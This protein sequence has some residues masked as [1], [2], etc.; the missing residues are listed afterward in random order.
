MVSKK[1]SPQKHQGSG[2]VPIQKENWSHGDTKHASISCP[3]NAVNALWMSDHASY[4]E[5]FLRK[6]VREVVEQKIL[7]KAHLFQR[8]RVNEAGISGVKPLKLCF[9]NK[10]P[11]TIFTRSNIIAE[12]ETPLQIA[13]I[14]VG[15]ESVVSDGPLSSLKI[16][17]YVLDGDFGSCGSEDWNEDEFNSN[18]LRERDGKEPLLI[19]ERII[20]LKNGVGC[21]T[22]LAFSDNSRWQRSR[23]FRIGVRVLQPISN[24]EKIQEAYK[25]HYPPYLNDDIWRLKNIAK[26]RKFHN[27]LSLH[28][29][30]KVKDLLRLYITNEPSLYEMFGNISR[31]SWLAITEHAK[32]CVIDDYKLYSYHSE[33]LQIGLLFN[34]IYILVGVTFDWQNYYSPDTL[35]PKEKHLVEIVKQ[36]AYRNVNNLKLIDD[37]K[38]NCLNLAAC[39]KARQS[40]TPDQGLQH[41]NISTAQVTLP[42]YSQP[43]ISAS[44]AD[45]GIMH[46]HQVYADLQP[47]IGEMSQNRYDLDEFSAGMYTEGDSLH[48][49]GSY[50]PF[51]QGGYSSENERS[52]IQFINDCPPY[53]TLVPETSF[54]IGSSVGAEFN[55]YSTFI[56]SAADISG[57]GKPK[58]VWY[59]ILVALKWVISIKRETA[60]RKNVKQFHYNY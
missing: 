52:V 57:T 15:S 2:K 28:G 33:E 49:N 54:F 11:D 17:I 39:L 37:T 24:G 9:I 45:E 6:V 21:I 23:R 41:I 13:L 44:Y 56:D 40:D 29:I 26:E 53:T 10:L 8:K 31:K 14:D 16:E 47:D 32:T 38:L 34:S 7:G 22:K 20:T 19:G 59:K 58:A 50:F 46:D 3:R 36:R 12:D 27:Q 43:F 30:H 5:N 55:N 25:K 4:W 18:I 42:G 51:V 35:P 60:A 1:Q 48:L